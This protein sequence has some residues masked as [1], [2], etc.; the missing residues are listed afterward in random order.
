M[1]LYIAFHLSNKEEEQC[2]IHAAERRYNEAICRLVESYQ[3]HGAVFREYYWTFKPRTIR[4]QRQPAHI[5]KHAEGS[6]PSTMSAARYVDRKWH[7]D[8]VFF[9][10]RRCGRLTENI[11][12][13]TTEAVR[14]IAL[15]PTGYLET[16]C[17]CRENSHR[18]G[19]GVDLDRPGL[20]LWND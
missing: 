3:A 17:L 1:M 12:K 4:Y 20:G 11:E 6:G 9:S 19:V 10:S 2:R 15:E 18:Y 5:A 8:C 16:I 7:L 14:M 13:L